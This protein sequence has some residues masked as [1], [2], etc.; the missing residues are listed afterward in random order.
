M[1][2]L[3]ERQQQQWG[4]CPPPPGPTRSPRSMPYIQ[5][6][7]GPAP[8]RTHAWIRLSTLPHHLC[9]TLLDTFS[10]SPTS[11][12]ASLTAYNSH[13][14]TS[15]IRLR[16]RTHFAVDKKKVCPSSLPGNV[17]QSACRRTQAP[18]LNTSTL[19][20]RTNQGKRIYFFFYIKFV[21]IGSISEQELRGRTFYQI[22]RIWKDNVLSVAS[23][24]YQ[25]NLAIKSPT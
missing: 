25:E 24:E 12:Q 2:C 4:C 21:L 10:L 22:F 5:A 7:W 9:C 18:P 3:I 16:T 1:Q 23:G 17:S 11:R 19:T 6:H 15:S 8:S 13:G 14:L 20:E